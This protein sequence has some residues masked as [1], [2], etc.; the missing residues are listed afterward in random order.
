MNELEIWEETH[1]KTGYSNKVFSLLDSSLVLDKF[2]DELLKIKNYYV[3]PKI[4]IPGCGSNINLQL[5]CNTVFGKDATISA[6][7]WSIKAIEISKHKTDMVGIN[8]D[9]FNQSFYDL[10][11]TPGSFDIIVMSNAIVS[12]TNEKNISAIKNLSSLLKPEGRLLG[13]MPSPFNMLDYALTNT[14]AGQWLKDGTVDITERRI[15][16][17]G[18][19][20]QRFFSPLELYVLFKDI[21]LRIEKFELFFFDDSHFAQQISRLYDMKCNERYCFWGY[22]INTI[23]L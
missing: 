14:E 15:N 7:D 12:E 22:F 1:G 13:L 8:V 17:K 19:G 21:K 3:H 23:K 20:S 16:E 10:S 9:Y 18:F 2:N 6:L 5:I 4:L 11:L